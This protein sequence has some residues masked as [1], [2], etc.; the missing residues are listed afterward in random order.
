MYVVAK[1]QIEDAERFLA[2]SQ[3]AAEQAPPGVYGRQFY[4]SRDRTE[5]VCLWEAD[6]LET[7]RDYLDSL[8]GEASENAY[9]QVGTDHAI[10]IPV[11]I[12]LSREISFERFSGSA[13]EN[14]E[15]YFVPAIGAPLATDLVELAALSPGSACWM[16][17]AEPEWWRGT[18]SSASATVEE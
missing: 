14:Y 8:V 1:H 7:V 5:A 16:S 2:L 6:S 13:A 12:G 18:L 17:P 3:I 10:G 4:P 9:F 11:P 15:R